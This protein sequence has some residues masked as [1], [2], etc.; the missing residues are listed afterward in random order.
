MRRSN[1]ENI[2]FGFSP[3]DAISIFLTIAYILI[4]ALYYFISGFGTFQEFT[5][6]Q[7][8]YQWIALTACYL[9]AL[10]TI[11]SDI[12]KFPLKIEQTKE[13]ALEDLLKDE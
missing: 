11:Y 4:S 2:E 8:F 13:E 3:K 9:F 1:L 12:I 5:Q 7:Y 6:T 10:F